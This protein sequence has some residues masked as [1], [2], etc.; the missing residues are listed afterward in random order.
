MLGGNYGLSLLMSNVGGVG[1]AV[2][3]IWQYSHLIKFQFKMDEVLWY[4]AVIG[5]MYFFLE[6]LIKYLLYDLYDLPQLS[7]YRIISALLIAPATEEII[8]RG[9]IMG[10]LKS[11]KTN[12]YVTVLTSALVFGL[13][14]IFNGGFPNTSLFIQSF[15]F[16]GLLGIVY[17]KTNNLLHP[18]LIHFIFNLL[19]VVGA[20]I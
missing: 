14:H 16:G 2:W 6:F 8:Y 7:I 18:I 4:A 9:W 1:V 10:Y 12:T 3:L 13:I 20:Y 5:V 11:K 17:L 19:M 15:L